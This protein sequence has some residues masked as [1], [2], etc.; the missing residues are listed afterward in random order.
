MHCDL[1]DVVVEQVNVHLLECRLKRYFRLRRM[2]KCLLVADGLLFQMPLVN[3]IR[4]A[5]E[6][7]KFLSRNLI[8]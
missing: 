6:A 2:K 5:R 8:S 3:P 7:V 1:N 4:G